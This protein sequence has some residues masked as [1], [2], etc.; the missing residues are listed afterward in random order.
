MPQWNAEDEYSSFARTADPDRFPVRRHALAFEIAMIHAA[1]SPVLREVPAVCAGW[2]RALN[3]AETSRVVDDLRVE[4]LEPQELVCCDG[5][6][7]LFWIGVI[8]G[9]I[10]ITKD[11]PDG[12]QTSLIGMPSNVWF[13]E[14]T[15]VK[16]DIWRFDAR[17]LRR[18]IVAKLPIA[19]FEWLLDRNIAFNRFILDQLN[20]R[21]G[22]FVECREIDRS[23][24][25][26]GKVSRSLSML[27][28]TS[29]PEDSSNVW[30][31]QDELASLCGLS[32]QR[33]NQ[34]LGTLKAAGLVKT[35]YGGI[36]V[37]DLKGLRQ[38][39][40]NPPGPG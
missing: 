27:F 23:I 1:P 19:T 14:G 7:A 20:A 17:A 10:A 3:P 13:G 21:L 25:T 28:N 34:A 18:T 24:D 5:K 11:Y 16:R 32:R 37:L 29:G 33:V 12:R 36:H 8:D 2:I 31:T 35:R 4:A 9:L 40:L 6:P 39:L 38:R 22:Q 26:D 15:L 30:I